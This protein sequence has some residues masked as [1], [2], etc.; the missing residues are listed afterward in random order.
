[1]LR[2]RDLDGLG[3]PDIDSEIGSAG[4]EAW[5]GRPALMNQP[6]VTASPQID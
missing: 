3:L 5:M 1:M 6:D 2:P 4:A